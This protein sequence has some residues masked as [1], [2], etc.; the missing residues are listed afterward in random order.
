MARALPQA[1]QIAN[2]PG[3]E[4]LQSDYLKFF[5]PGQAILEK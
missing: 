3:H 2:D 4:R 1:L 5:A